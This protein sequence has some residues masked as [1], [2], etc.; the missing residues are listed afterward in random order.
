M[1]TKNI[2]KPTKILYNSHSLGRVFQQVRTQAFCSRLL[3]K[4]GSNETPKS[5]KKVGAKTSTLD[6]NWAKNPNL[7]IS[8]AHKLTEVEIM[9]LLEKVVTLPEKR[10][11][12][13]LKSTG[14]ADE[15]FMQNLKVRLPHFLTATLVQITKVCGKYPEIMKKSDIWVHLELEFL[16]RSSKLNNQHLA[17][18]LLS[19]ASV[20]K[21][22]ELFFNQMEEVIV[23]SPIMFEEKHLFKFTKAFTQ[24]NYGG[25]TLYAY[26]SKMFKREIDT[27]HP[28]RMAEICALFSRSTNSHKAGFGFYHECEKQVKLE[29]ANNRLSF[30]D[31]T[32][33]VESLFRNNIGSTEFQEQLEEYLSNK[34]EHEKIPELL[35]LTKALYEPGY[36]VKSQKLQD[37]LFT[38]LTLNMKE[39]TVRQVESLF[40]AL[41]RNQ[42][43]YQQVKQGDTY[44][45][46][47]TKGLLGIVHKRCVSMK[48]RGIKYI[49]NGM[50]S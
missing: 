28:T 21:G 48:A 10:L 33:I 36:A 49:L 2:L 6:K 41:T 8:N 5:L 16:K 29:M 34:L 22:S 27:M 19:F 23:D 3:S 47:V 24:L 45:K 11:E 25:P 42:R 20:G 7:V 50:T 13:V 38:A 35:R 32:K 30:S 37:D 17:D 12:K 26:L 40:W 9:N 4:R 31:G 15:D 46:M 44:A 14:Q 1:F 43:L 18:V 39:M